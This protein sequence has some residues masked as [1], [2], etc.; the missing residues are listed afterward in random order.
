MLPLLIKGLEL[1]KHSL[2][3]GQNLEI[4]KKDH[5]FPESQKY[6]R[7]KMK[8]Y[9]LLDPSV[10]VLKETN[11]SFEFLATSSVWNYEKQHFS[12]IFVALLKGTLN[13][14]HN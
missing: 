3:S 14:W 2:T 9:I 7:I 6:S 13:T 10:D 8:F 5:F 12:E 4:K 1:K 11:Y